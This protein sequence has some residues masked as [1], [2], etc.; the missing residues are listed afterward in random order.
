MQRQS[1]IVRMAAVLV[2]SGAAAMALAGPPE[3]GEA[4]AKPAIFSDK[5][6]A[7]A[8]AAS[9]TPGKITVVKATAEWCAPCKRMDKTTFVDEK[10]IK[11]FGDHGLIIEF[12]VDKDR[13]LAADL[14]VR[15]MPTTIAFKE[16]KEVDRV[17]GYRDAA[18]LLGWLERVRT[19]VAAGD[20]V[21]ATIEKT[22]ED[23]SKLTMSARMQRA[24]SLVAAGKAA[25][26]ADE[27]VWLWENMAKRDPAMVGVRGS[28]LV[29]DIQK[30]IAQHP[31]A[32]DQFVAVRDRNWNSYQAN[33]ED[34]NAFSD[35][36]SL[37]SLLREDDKTLAWFDAARK[38]PAQSEALLRA[39]GRLETI[40]VK[41]GR[42]ADVASLYADPLEPVRT[43]ARM[44]AEFYDKMGDDENSR[45]VREVNAQA[46]RTRVGNLYAALLLSQR[47]DDARKVA[48]EALKVDDSAA[49]RLAMARTAIENQAGR[50]E[51]FEMLD[52]AGRAG[53]AVDGLRQQLEQQVGK[54]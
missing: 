15:A 50:R 30:L 49:L 24:S 12:D 35:W 45:N 2:F 43:H 11:W 23:L 41:Q 42:L 47:D 40:L 7:D 53:E 21:T 18:G 44:K 36:M 4:T 26:A 27:Y 46:F 1:I 33:R 5:S 31:P 8:V 48:A 22:P 29:S 17:V 28:F 39:T 13:Q 16:G 38:D 20:G 25:E 34:L 3:A 32:R 14:N 10:V 51:H 52:S 54:P 9:K 19:G 6:F 37:N